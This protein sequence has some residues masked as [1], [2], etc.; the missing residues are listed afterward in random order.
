MPRSKSQTRCKT[1]YT[2]EGT[3]RDVCGFFHGLPHTQAYQHMQVGMETM[4]HLTC[5]NMPMEKLEDA[6]EKVH[7]LRM[8]TMF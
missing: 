4:M 3:T 7:V 8:Q 5:T 2:D 6:L 1:R